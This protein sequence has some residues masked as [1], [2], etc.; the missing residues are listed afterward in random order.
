MITDLN[1]LDDGAEIDADVGII[2]GGAAGIALALEMLGDRLQVALVES[3]GFDFEAESQALYAGEVTGLVYFPLDSARL[4]QFGGSTNHWGGQS[5]PLQ[6]IDFQERDWVP[7]SG[8][9]ID[10]DEFARYLPRAEP[11]CRLTLE[12]A[13]QAV[14]DLGPEMPTFPLGEAG[15]QPVPLRFPQTGFSFG[16]LHRRALERAPQVGCYLHAN[17]VGFDT[18]PLRRR[19]EAVRL[20][21]LDGRRATLRARSYV[22]AAG[23]IETCRLLLAAGLGTQHDMVGRCVME[24]P[25]FDTGLVLLGD[26]PYLGSAMRRVGTQRV[27]LDAQLSPEA[28]AEA[29]ILNHTVFLVREPE[30]R[31]GRIERLWDRIAERVTGPEDEAFVLRVR[32]EHAPDPESR[33]TLLEARDALGMPQAALN[34]RVGTLEAR[35]IEHVC[36]AFARAIGMADLG[37]MQVTFDPDGWQDELGWQYHHCGGTRMHADPRRGVV[38]ADCRVHGLD[39]LYVAGSSI[40]PTSGHANPTM[41]LLAFTIRLADHLKARAQA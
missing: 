28:Q 38:D 26:D 5:V 27:R 2:G 19:I 36:D 34:Y 10:Y 6:P 4:R 41:N 13:G 7:D 22:L 33:I 39:N 15:F 18:D 37:R 11:L 40:F 21:S 35:T 14:W 17:A 3:G 23:G 8:W 29:R 31:P 1:A 9:P 24:H 12:E 16:S 25:N 20:R 32:L 30:P